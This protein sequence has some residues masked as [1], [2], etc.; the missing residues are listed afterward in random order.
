MFGNGTARSATIPASCVAGIR[1]TSASGGMGSYETIVGAVI[2][3]GR[4]CELDPPVAPPTC[5]ELG[6]CAPPTC[7]ELGNCEPP[8]CEELGNCEP[9][10]CEELNPPGFDVTFPFANIQGS[11]T[12]KNQGLWNLTL[13]ATSDFSDYE[14]DNPEYTKNYANARWGRRVQV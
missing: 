4:N 6:N 7:E 3:T 10:T 5:E 1:P 9:P 8:T 2:D 12:V 11:A 13:Y 14:D